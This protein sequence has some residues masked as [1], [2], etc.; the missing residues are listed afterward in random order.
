MREACRAQPRQRPRSPAPRCPSFT[1]HLQSNM[2]YMQGSSRLT[3]LRSYMQVRENGAAKGQAS[4]T[5]AP[6]DAR[7]SQSIKIRELDTVGLSTVSTRRL[8]EPAAAQTLQRHVPPVR[9][10]PAEPSSAEDWRESGNAAFKRGDWAGA[11]QA[12]SRC[13]C[14][15]F[16]S[17]RALNL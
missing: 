15:A 8:T 4:N 7:A 10:P 12:Y 13:C 11:R 16:P 5:P 17:G 14:T 9:Q 1:D 2:C 3:L 6:P